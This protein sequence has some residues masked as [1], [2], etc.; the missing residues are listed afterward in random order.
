[1]FPQKERLKNLNEAKRFLSGLFRTQHL[2]VLATQH[3]G[4]PYVSLV[5]FAHMDDLRHLLFAT[6]RATRK[7]SYLSEDS[8]IALL[9]D[10]RLNADSDFHNASAV[11]VIGSAAEGE[12]E[13]LLLKVYLD[14][15]PYLRD[16]VQ[17]PTCALI[18]VT[19]QKYLIV[20]R[21]QNVTEVQVDW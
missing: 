6:T 19:V 9:I 21:F 13:P 8:R 1:M 10:N 17:A 7:Y 14:K 20:Q 12:K 11:T 15:V 2:A 4:A 16:F 18:R 5:A 3:R